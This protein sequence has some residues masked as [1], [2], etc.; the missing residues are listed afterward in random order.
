MAAETNL[1]I[2]G[3]LTANPELRTTSSGAQ[4]VSLTIAS[5]PRTYNR[6]TNQWEDGQ[7]LFMRCSA[8]RDLALNITQTLTKGMRVIAQGRLTQRTWQAADGSQRT[9]VELQIDDI[10]PSLRHAMATVV[11]NSN[12]SQTSQT[13]GATF[14]TPNGTAQVQM[15]DEAADPWASEP[16]F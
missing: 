2:V 9:A 15:M 7:T 4:V 1:T 10:G 13:A 14:N 3:N 8:W 16:A 11:K 6:N 5:T 12:Q